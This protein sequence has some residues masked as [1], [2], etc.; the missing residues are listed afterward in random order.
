M[1]ITRLDHSRIITIAAFAGDADP[2]VTPPDAANVWEV[3]EY[4]QGDARG[5]GHVLVGAFNASVPT[6]TLTFRTWWKDERSGEWFILGEDTLT[7]RKGQ[8]TSDMVAGIIFV[9]ALVFANVGAATT[10]T[11]YAG[12]V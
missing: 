1:A 5:N 2:N 11:I 6:G 4:R 9:Q 7:H 3:N 10:F 12:E 8:V